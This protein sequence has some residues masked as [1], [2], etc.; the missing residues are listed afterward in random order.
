M[1]SSWFAFIFS[2]WI[3]MLSKWGLLFVSCICILSLIDDGAWLHYVPAAWVSINSLLFCIMKVLDVSPSYTFSSGLGGVSLMYWWIFSSSLV[4]IFTWNSF[5]GAGVFK[6]EFVV[7]V[8][9]CIDFVLLS[10]VLTLLILA[11][12]YVICRYLASLIFSDR[13]S[14]LILE[15]FVW[16]GFS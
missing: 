10:I 9:F 11:P 15:A 13:F 5:P 12:Y 6:T 14:S 8:I 2:F 3:R 16:S 4:R 1:V 7:S